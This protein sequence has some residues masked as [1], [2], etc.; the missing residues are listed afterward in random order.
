MDQNLWNG[1]KYK[2]WPAI[3]DMYYLIGEK[4]Q[5]FKNVG[6]KWGRWIMEWNEWNMEWSEVWM[7]EVKW[8]MDEWMK[9]DGP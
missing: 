7:N 8:S 1:V 3:H 4:H 6:L 2:K 9:W 5:T